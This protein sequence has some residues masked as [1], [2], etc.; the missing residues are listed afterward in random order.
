MHIPHPVAQTSRNPTCAACYNCSPL[1]LNYTHLPTSSSPSYNVNSLASTTYF[2]YRYAERTSRL[3][4]TVPSDSFPLKPDCFI[5]QSQERTRQKLSISWLKMPNCHFRCVLN[6]DD[7]SICSI[8]PHASFNGSILAMSIPSGR[9]SWYFVQVN[10]AYNL[11]PAV[12][13]WAACRQIIALQNITN[14]AN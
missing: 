14:R 10:S 12:V 2:I 11:R 7:A 3:E 5:H 4:P 9:A 6:L 8:S 13:E 1:F